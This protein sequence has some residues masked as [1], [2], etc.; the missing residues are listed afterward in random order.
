MRRDRL[1]PLQLAMA[2]LVLGLASLIADALS[3]RWIGAVALAV[4]ALLIGWW[5]FR[6]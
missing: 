4:G 2:V 1:S 3:A 5:Y 6:A